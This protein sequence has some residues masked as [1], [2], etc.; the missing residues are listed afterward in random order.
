MMFIKDGFMIVDEIDM[1]GECCNIINLKSIR[2]I[3]ERTGRTV[4]EFDHDKE[5]PYKNKIVVKE[6]LDEIMAELGFEF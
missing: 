1:S 2:R 3:Y 5:P 6:S 4:I